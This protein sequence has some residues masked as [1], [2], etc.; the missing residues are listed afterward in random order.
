E[1]TPCGASRGEMDAA[2]ILGSVGRVALRRPYDAPPARIVCGGPYASLRVVN[3]TGGPIELHLSSGP[4]LLRAR[5]T[6]L[7]PTGEIASDP[8]QWLVAQGQVRLMPDR[9]D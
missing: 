5:G 6:L 3:L 4:T 7:P 8:L 9:Q 2:A 1:A